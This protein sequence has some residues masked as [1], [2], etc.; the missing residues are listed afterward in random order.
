MITITPKDAL[1]AKVLPPGWQFC[2]V[3]NHYTKP[4]TS[5]G[6]TVHYYELTVVGGQFKDVPLAELTLSEKAIG[7]GKNFFIAAGMPLELWDKAEKGESI[8]FDE[9]L[10]VGKYVKTMV[11]PEPFGNRVLNKAV[12]FMPVKPEELAQFGITV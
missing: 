3:E 4:A 12:D 7:M 9:K 5:D 6:S 2:L 8:N 10:P 11:K 1:R